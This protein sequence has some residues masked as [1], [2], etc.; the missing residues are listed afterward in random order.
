MVNAHFL[1]TLMIFTAMIAIG[2]VGVL[3]ISFW[4][5]SENSEQNTAGAVQ[6][7]ESR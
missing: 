7:G 3:L 5:D 1:K 2:L 4:Q 6:V